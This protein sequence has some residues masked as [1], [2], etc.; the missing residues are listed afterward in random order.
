MANTGVILLIILAIILTITMISL[1]I[2]AGVSYINSDRNNGGTGTNILPPCNQN[3]NI[4]SLI[5][6][7]DVG[8]NCIQNGIV[9][10][11]YYIG[12][13][14]RGQYDYVVAPWATQPLDVCV[15]FCTGYTG[16]QCSG[17]DYNGQ[18]AQSNFDN[19]MRQLSST[20][21]APPIPIAARGTIIYYPLSPT[22]KICDN[23]G[24][25]ISVV[26]SK[27]LSDQIT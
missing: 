19:C 14:D 12:K 13:L 4:S 27:I 16:G 8:A 23:C 15:G 1:L 17:A 22:C 11:L 10:S 21:C 6:I 24:S 7:P 20:G 3:V 25:Q 9:G 18:S 2:W 26:E 5:Q